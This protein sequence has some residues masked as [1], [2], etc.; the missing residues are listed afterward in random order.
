[1]KRWEEEKRK[2]SL[3]FASKNNIAVDRT[4]SAEGAPRKVIKSI[5]ATAK[6][7]FWRQWH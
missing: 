3:E 5:K 1:M 4:S 6:V 2:K 7:A